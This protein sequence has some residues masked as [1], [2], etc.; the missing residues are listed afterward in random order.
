MYT[1]HTNR[2]NATANPITNERPQ[3]RIPTQTRPQPQSLQHL[4]RGKL[5]ILSYI[6]LCVFVGYFAQIQVAFFFMGSVVGILLSVG[7]IVLEMGADL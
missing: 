4:S 7:V 3:M 5:A 1:G 2:R 6:L